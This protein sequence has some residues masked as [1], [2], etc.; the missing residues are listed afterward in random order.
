MKVSYE[1]E[2]EYS[3]VCIVVGEMHEFTM[4]DSTQN[5]RKIKLWLRKRT[6]KL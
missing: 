2:Y 6:I 4:F 5:E 1:F 3:F